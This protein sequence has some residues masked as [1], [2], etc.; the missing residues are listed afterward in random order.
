DQMNLE[1]LPERQIHQV[2]FDEI[3]PSGKCARRS[4]A[5]A[6]CVARPPRDDQLRTRVI[7]AYSSPPLRW[8][9]VTPGQNAEGSLVGPAGGRTDGPT[10]AKSQTSSRPFLSA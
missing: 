10:T 9:V 7:L 5:T 3:V 8:Q 6:L 1:L 2:R 4:D